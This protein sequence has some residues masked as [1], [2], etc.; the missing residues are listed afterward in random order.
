MISFTNTI[1][2]D[3]PTEEVYAYLAELEHI[4]EWNWAITS[5]RKISEGPVTAGTRYEQTRHTPTTAIEEIVIIALETDRHLHIEGTLGPFRADLRYDIEPDGDKSK[6]TNHVELV[7]STPTLALPLA[8]IAIPRA[9][10]ANLLTLKTRLEQE[11]VSA[12][13]IA[14]PHDAHSTGL[15]SGNPAPRLART[16][17]LPGPWSLRTTDPTDD[18]SGP[19]GGDQSSENNRR[20]LRARQADDH[21]CPRSFVI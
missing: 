5:T 10:A 17:H 9:V 11:P 19:D 1:A 16:N 7:P 20:L 15:A 12:R 14:L 18:R 2:I 6:L 13:S 8:R 4:P 21:Q 3:R